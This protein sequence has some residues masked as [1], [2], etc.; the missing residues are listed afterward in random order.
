[1]LY[2]VA[3][4]LGLEVVILV[5]LSVLVFMNAFIVLAVVCVGGMYKVMSTNRYYVCYNI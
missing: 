2:Y 1:M 4:G 5:S 3:A